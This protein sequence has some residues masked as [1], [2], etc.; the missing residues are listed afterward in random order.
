MAATLT[1]AKAFYPGRR[2]V[3]VFQPHHHSRLTALFTEFTQSFFAA[4]KVIILETYSVPG[5][6]VPE[7]ASKTSR[8]LQS[9]LTAAGVDASYAANHTEAEAQLKTLLQPGD[10]AVV[11]G[12]GDIWHLADSLTHVYA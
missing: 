11:M 1:G 7:V 8:E 12:A 2:L 4:D 9:Q 3:A 6:E 10:V 5:R